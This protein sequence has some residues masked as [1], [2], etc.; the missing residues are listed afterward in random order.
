LTSTET[1]FVTSESLESEFERYRQMNERRVNDLE[2]WRRIVGSNIQGSGSMPPSLMQQSSSMQIGGMV[3]NGTQSGMS[4]MGPPSMHANPR[5]N[6][7]SGVQ[8]GTDPIF[9]YQPR[10]DGSHDI[11]RDRQMSTAI[12]PLTHLDPSIGNVSS[13]GPPVSA[14]SVDPGDS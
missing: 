2:S 8:L 1:H 7:A 3:Y 4:D 14:R 5:T 9:G 13:G 6:Q 10:N 11:M 12:S